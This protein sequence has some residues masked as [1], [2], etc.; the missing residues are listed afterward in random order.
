LNVLA[1]ATLHWRGIAGA[2]AAL[3]L[4]QRAAANDPDFVPPAWNIAQVL[5]GSDHCDLQARAAASVRQ[6]AAGARD[7]RALVGPVLPVGFS[8]QSVDWSLA[9]QACVRT[10]SPA[11]A[12]ALLP[13]PDSG[14]AHRLSPAA[15]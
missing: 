7:W 10:G 3:N 9:V 14:G 6:R 1:V 8:A 12:A 2:A 11:D 4:L 13:Q 15:G 5:A